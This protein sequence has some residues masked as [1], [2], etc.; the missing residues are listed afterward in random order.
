MYDRRGGIAMDVPSIKGL[1]LGPTCDRV[2]ALVEKGRMSQRDLEAT[3]HPEDLRLLEEGPAPTLW[4]PIAS[5]A[6]LNELLIRESGGDGPK[7]MRELGAGALDSLLQGGGSRLFL[8]GIRKLGNRASDALV[9][10]AR[11]LLNFGEWNYRQDSPQHAVIE[12]RQVQ[13]LPETLRFAIEGLI[14]VMIPEFL[15]MTVIVSSE[16]P[17]PDRILFNCRVR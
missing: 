11:L 5:V 6:R 14:E 4:Y 1:T 7:L 16:R 17:A 15:G 3:L 12:A 8:E 9:E 13:P 10:L 2:N